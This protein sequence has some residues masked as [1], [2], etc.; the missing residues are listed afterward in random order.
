MANLLEH[1]I[2]IDKGRIIMNDDA[3]TIRGSAFTVVGSAAAVKSFL[4]HREVLHTDR[5]A[6][7]ASVT[8]LG[9]LDATDKHEAAELGLEL[10]Q[11]SLQQLVIRKTLA[12]TGG[13]LGASDTASVEVSQ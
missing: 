4:G 5:F 8:A 6:S 13:D 7:L 3:E 9:V 11:V 12:A 10:A 2:V 1:V